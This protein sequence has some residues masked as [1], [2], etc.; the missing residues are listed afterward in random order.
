[1]PPGGAFETHL[2]WE[3]PASATVSTP[4]GRVPVHDDRLLSAALVSLYDEL[5]LT[6]LLRTGRGESTVIRAEDPLEDMRF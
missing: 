5:V 6:G 1:M 4:G 3:V 2:K